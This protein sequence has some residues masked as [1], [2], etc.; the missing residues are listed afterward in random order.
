MSGETTQRICGLVDFDKERDAV[1]EE[2]SD[3]DQ[4]PTGEAPADEDDDFDLLAF[5]KSAPGNVSLESMMTEIRKLTAVRSIELPPGLFADVA[6][7]V[8]AAWRARAAVEAP[9]HMRTHP[10]ELTVLLLAALIHEREREITDTLVELLIA[11]VHRIKAR[12]DSKVTKEL[13]DAFKRVTGKENILFKVADAALGQPDDP[14]RQ[15]SRG[16]MALLDTL[17]FKSNNTAYQPVIEA[18]EL[19]RRYAKAGNTTYYPRGET[20]PEHRGTAGDWEDLVFK[21]DKRGRRRVVRMVY[22]IVTFQTLRDAPAS[23]AWARVWA[24]WYGSVPVSMTLP[25]RGPRPRGPEASVAAPD[26]PP[27]LARS[28]R[29]RPRSEGAWRLRRR[30]VRGDERRRRAPGR[31]PAGDVQGVGEAAQHQQVGERSQAALVGGDLG[32]RISGAGA[33]LGQG[34]P[35]GL[36]CLTD[37]PAVVPTGGAS[38]PVRGQHVLLPVWQS[39]RGR[40]VRCVRGRAAGRLA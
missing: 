26:H 8:L 27:L 25:P 35:G 10:R 37:D 23:S 34:E 5:I 12:A 11:T 31:R 33:E 28:S 17:E 2:P 18:L 16:L 6:P 40:A 20:V 22:E 15:V 32:G 36:A 4:M 1:D 7:K 19:I 29:C 30:A 38:G 13:I 39:M 14:V 21:K 9:S 24:S 3:G